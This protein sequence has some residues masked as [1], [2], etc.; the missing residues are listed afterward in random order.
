MNLPIFPV[1]VNFILV[2]IGHRNTLYS[3]PFSFHGYISL[4]SRGI[5]EL[6][7][8]ANVGFLYVISEKTTVNFVFGCGL[9]RS[10]MK[11]W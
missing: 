5:Q 6:L 2:S 3:T 10:I 8:T 4:I 11:G 1:R 7:A 9:W